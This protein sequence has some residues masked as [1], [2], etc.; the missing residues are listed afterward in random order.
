MFPWSSMDAEFKVVR[1]LPGFQNITSLLSGCHCFCWEINSKYCCFFENHV[2]C[3]LTAS[4]IFLLSLI[5]SNLTIM[6]KGVVF[7]VFIL[8]RF[9]IFPNSIWC[10]L[11]ILEIL[12]QHL[13]KHFFYPILFSAFFGPL[14]SWNAGVQSILNFKIP[15]IWRSFYWSLEQNTL[16]LCFFLWENK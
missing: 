10:L 6:C 12:R 5:F 7:F 11:S 9:I 8:L 13:F 4:S 2:F 14:H 16:S 15:S 1:I 3:S